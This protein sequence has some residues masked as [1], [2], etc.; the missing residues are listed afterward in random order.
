MNA[1]LAPRMVERGYKLLGDAKTAAA[2]L[3]ILVLGSVS[4]A[5]AIAP[6]MTRRDEL[7]AIDMDC[8]RCARFAAHCTEV[9]LGDFFKLNPQPG[10]KA[11]LIVMRP[12]AWIP[13]AMIDHAFLNWLAPGG[14]IV[15]MVPDG[16]VVTLLAA[17]RETIEV[18]VEREAVEGGLELVTIKRKD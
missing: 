13:G 10:K 14:V 2:S 11:D 12:N 6:R 17:M 3:R 9:V 5:A 8:D 15:A 7:L 4:I 1:D 16:S 18:T